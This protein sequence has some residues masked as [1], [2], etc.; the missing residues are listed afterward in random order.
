[1]KIYFSN[2]PHYE[3]NHIVSL[4][5]NWKN[6]HFYF[7]YPTT[8]RFL[9]AY[10]IWSQ[11]LLKL[12]FLTH[13]SFISIIIIL[14]FYLYFSSYLDVILRLSGGNTHSHFFYSTVCISWVILS[15]LTCPW[16]K[17]ASKHFIFP[18]AYMGGIFY[19]PLHI[20]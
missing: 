14:F 7:H 10:L 15:Y 2:Y 6:L 11:L 9:F 17:Y 13:V 18:P 3:T 19:K 12:L 1:M 20:W 4:D 16:L 5:V 8:S